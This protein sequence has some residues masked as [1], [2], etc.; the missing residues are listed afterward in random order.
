LCEKLWGLLLSFR[1]VGLHTL[2]EYVLLLLLLL[3][4]LL[5]RLRHRYERKVA[6]QKAKEVREGFSA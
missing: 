3:L 1:P 5:N 4:L 2:Q 6:E